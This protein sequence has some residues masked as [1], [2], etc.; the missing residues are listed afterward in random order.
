M[1]RHKVNRRSFAA[2]GAAAASLPM[3]GRAQSGTP[4][5]SPGASPAASPAAVD[6]QLEG[7]VGSDGHYV[8]SNPL[9][10][11]AWTK[12]QP[13]TKMYDSAPASGGRVSC[14][15][16]TYNPPPTAKADNVWWQDLETRLNVEWNAVITPHAN[17]GEKA[18]TLIASGDMPDL[19]YINPGQTDAPLLSFVAEGAFVDLT[20]YLTGDALQEYPSLAKYQQYHWDVATMNGQIYGVPNPQ[21]K[22][23]QLPFFRDDWAN[24]LGGM[25]TNA[26]EVHDVLVG[27]S[28]NDPDANGANDTYGMAMYDGF[29]SLGLLDRMFGVPNGWRVDAD[30]AFVSAS[31]TEEVREFM[32]YTK[33]LFADGAYHPDATGM[34]FSDAVNLFTSGRAGVFSDGWK[35]FGPD[36]YLRM[37]HNHQPDATATYILPPGKDGGQGVAHNGTGTFGV[38]AIPATVTDPERIREL[39]RIV[40]YLSAPYGTEEYNFFYHGLEGVHHTINDNGFPVNT[41][42]YMADWGQLT[43]YL[44]GPLPVHIDPVTPMLGPFM[45]DLDAKALEIGVDDPT[46]TLFSPTAVADN[47][48]IGQRITDA[49]ND[50]ITG[51]GTIEAFDEAVAAWREAVGDQVRSEFEEAWAANN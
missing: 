27:M 33:T 21:R 23:P 11:D 24:K 34:G 7:T 6:I 15:I 38:T 9:A 42:Q 13:L 25:P 51:R 8:P 17:Y 3:I 43:S 10:P 14:L 49:Q 36:G 39:L 5:A 50:F 18:T 45:S 37:I 35:I 4:A 1:S 44:G 30:G 29:W 32:E 48:G 16:M 41:D 22:A 20:E 47:S 19:F 46:A 2:M 26:A 28:L 40:D 31:E 12:P